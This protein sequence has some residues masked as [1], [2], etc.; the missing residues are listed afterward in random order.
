MDLKK[1]RD[2]VHLLCQKYEI[3]LGEWA[4][5]MENE[6]PVLEY[7]GQRIEIPY[8]RYI[9]S[10]ISMRNCLTDGTVLQKSMM[11]TTVIDTAEI[12]LS[13]MILRETDICLWMMD[14]KVESVYAL[15]N[16]RTATIIF[17][18]F[19]GMVG[20]ID[21]ANTL[22][23]GQ[24]PIQ[25][26][27]IIGTDGVVTNKSVDELFRQ[28][29]LYCFSADGRVEGYTDFDMELYGYSIDECALVRSILD[30]LENQKQSAYFNEVL[31]RARKIADAVFLAMEKEQK[32]IL[33]D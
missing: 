8:W 14:D 5:S 31:F 23:S 27:E 9:D 13:K 33:E 30:I 10:Y 4:V 24:A 16:D 11:K 6:I 26:Y 1:C 17:R 32:L 20:T 29:A 15:G 22:A 28:D 18:F 3:E 25:R 2:G 7:L 21:V 19:S 12:S